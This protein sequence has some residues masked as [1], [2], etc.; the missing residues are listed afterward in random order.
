[1][2]SIYLGRSEYVYLGR[3]AAGLLVAASGRGTACRTTCASGH[4]VFHL[5][6]GDGSDQPRRPTRQQSRREMMC[7]STTEALLIVFDTNAVNLLSPSSL[8][9]D[10]IRKLRQSGHHKV[11]VPW[12]VMEELVAHRTKHYPAKHQAAANTLTKLREALPWELESSLEPLDLNRFVNHWRGVYEE[13]FEVIDTSG[14]TARM[15]LSREAMALPPAKR[16]NDHSEGARDVAVWFSILEY[17]KKNPNENICFVTNNTKDFGDGTTYPYPMDEDLRGL[18]HRLTRLAGFDDVV[19]KFTK[20]VS[21]QDAEVAAEKLLRSLSVREGVAGAAVEVL[22]SPVGFVGLDTAEAS[23]RWRQWLTLPETELLTIADVTGHEIEGNVWYTANTRWL[24]YGATFGENTRNV[25]C[26][27]EVRVLFSADGEEEPPTLLARGAPML[28]D[29]ADTR[30]MKVLKE[31]KAR[32]A[33]LAKQTLKNRPLRS[34]VEGLIAQSFAQ[35]MPKIDIA[36]LLP[37]FSVTEALARD[38]VSHIVASIPTLDIAASLDPDVLKHLTDGIDFSGL[39]PQ[40]DIGPLLPEVDFSHLLAHANINELVA[41]SLAQGL[42]APSEDRDEEEDQSPD[43][44]GEKDSHTS[45]DSGP[46]DGDRT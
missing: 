28:P 20:E 18:E 6:K 41:G 8:Q 36:G 24:L 17:L 27:W 32:A 25:S 11:A 35:S 7:A 26:V 15:A 43:E 14:D 31:L 37:D 33:R 42:D 39:V 19:S 13:V 5:L 12:V 16:A 21:G 45:D 29:T 3:C 30:C 44:D 1:M 23:V 38:A 4:G 9:A 40:L 10:I 34:P 46:P 22:R 2:T